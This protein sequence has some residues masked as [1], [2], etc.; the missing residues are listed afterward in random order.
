MRSRSGSRCW[1]RTWPQIPPGPCAIRPPL[2]PPCTQ[3]SPWPLPMR[4]PLLWMPPPAPA[5]APAPSSALARPR[6]RSHQGRHRHWG[7]SLVPWKNV[8][9]LTTVATSPRQCRADSRLSRQLLLHLLRR[10]ERRLSCGLLWTTRPE[11]P[12]HRT[13]QHLT[14]R[15]YNA[16]R[17]TT[18]ASRHHRL[19]HRQQPKRCQILP[20]PKTPAVSKP[21]P[22]RSSQELASAWRA[23]RRQ[24]SSSP[25][26]PK[27]PAV[28]E[29]RC[30][31]RRSRRRGS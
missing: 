6:R 1:R 3:R 27:T 24:L 11:A 26:S 18:P 31:Q 10:R 21:R 8:S 25:S 7:L 4:E 23:P 17:W 12:R 30:H 15:S 28:S 29:P 9:C 19:W 16:Q 5:A 22:F 14:Q 13:Q 2:S 20:S